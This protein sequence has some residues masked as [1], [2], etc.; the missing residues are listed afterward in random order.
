MYVFIQIA[1]LPIGFV[2]VL[3]PTRAELAEGLWPVISARPL[4]PLS[5]SPPATWVQL[6]RFA[7]YALAF[8]LARSLISGSSR[9]RV[10]TY[11]W[12]VMGIGALQAV[13]GLIQWSTA[14]SEALGSYFDRNMFAWL[15]EIAL[16]L[17]LMYG[18]A[19][20]TRRS[21]KTIKA[22]GAF[23][24][25]ILVLL[26]LAASLSKTGFLVAVGSLVLLAAIGVVSSVQGSMRWL[27][28]AA[29]GAVAL[30][31][32]FGLPSNELTNRLGAI[33]FD[34]TA[35]GRVPIWKDTLRLIAAY[36]LFGT[37]LGNYS[38]AVLRYRTSELGAAWDYA[39]NDYLQLLSELGAVGFGLAAALVCTLAAIAVRAALRGTDPD[40]RLFGLGCLGVLASTVVHSATYFNL[41]MSAGG[42]ALSWVCG[43]MAGVPRAIPEARSANPSMLSKA[44]F[45]LAGFGILY[46]ATSF[47][48][49]TLGGLERSESAFC[50]I[51]ICDTDARWASLWGLE[52]SHAETNRPGEALELL[53][54]EPAGPARWCDVG[55]VMRNAGLKQGADYCFSRALKLGPNIPYINFRVARYEFGVGRSDFGFDAMRKALDGDEAYAGQAF[56]IYQASRIPIEVVVRQGLPNRSVAQRYVRYLLADNPVSAQIA[57]SYVLERGWVDDAL[58]GGYAQGLINRKQAASAAEAWGEYA[59]SRCPGYLK[60]T[61][62]F[63]GGFELNPTRSPFDWRIVERPGVTVSI[64]EQLAYTGRK[65]ARIDFDGTENVNKSLMSQ[66]AYLPPGRYTFRARMKSDGLTTN[67]GPLFEIVGKGLHVATEQLTGSSDWHLIEATFD[68]PADAGLVD[69]RLTRNES[70]KFDN[71]IK[72]TVWVDDVAIVPSEQGLGTRDQGYS[73]VTQ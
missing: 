64:D 1:P 4:T 30:L 56:E 38:P 54:R 12:P 25:A 45:V 17:L 43:L 21:S 51:G 20:L 67:Q 34:P 11:A 69:L 22:Y 68:V 37:G 36:P 53:T 27:A 5:I 15:L 2:R 73:P 60:S 8:L 14:E 52:E 10:W 49:M 65:S 42:M 29:V 23:G 50:R 55:D 58:A 7:E 57:W 24:L 62:V 72:G 61:Y 46:G 41:Y 33:L 63:N 39:H 71:K 26:A 44:Q 48:V 28:A 13:W 18:L 3:S 32:L 9:R 66:S 59:G 70:L 35:E 31:A 47:A 16:P 6:S 40:E 19:V